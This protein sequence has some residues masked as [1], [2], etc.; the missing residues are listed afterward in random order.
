MRT[1]T[2]RYK[3]FYIKTTLFIFDFEY[4][5]TNVRLYRVMS[6]VLE[7]RRTLEP[8]IT[9]TDLARRCHDALLLLDT[10]YIYRFSTTMLYL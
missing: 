10:F 1:V 5:L 4:K 7:R 9:K 3:R 2:E 6:S 8:D